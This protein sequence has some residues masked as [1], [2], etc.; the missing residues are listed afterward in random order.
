MDLTPPEGSEKIEPSSVTVI[1]K[2]EP[3]GEKQISSLPIS[4]KL[5]NQH[6]AATIL[7]P[8]DKRMSLRVLGAKDILDKLKPEEIMITA[9][10]ANL[11]PGTHT[12]PVV[13][14]LPLHVRLAEGDTSRQIVIELTEKE[15]PANPA[16]TEPEGPSDPGTSEQE[17]APT[18][19]PEENT[20]GN[21]NGAN[22]EG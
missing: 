10:L 14:T 11:G 22:T 12:V 17:T 19:P 1:V 21:G 4:L 7:D 3:P 8:P 2:V 9:D 20:A 5:D 18:V 15:E 16:N 6:L 13:V